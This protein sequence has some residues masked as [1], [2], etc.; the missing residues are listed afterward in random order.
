MSTS[1]RL[2]MPSTFSL[3]RLEVE[4]TRKGRCPIMRFAMPTGLLAGLIAVGGLLANAP[5]AAAA[6]A[7][8][9]TGGLRSPGHA[10]PRRRLIRKHEVR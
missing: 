6:D 4:A 9:A 7:A 5:V 2:P 8:R 10:R 1:R 3:R